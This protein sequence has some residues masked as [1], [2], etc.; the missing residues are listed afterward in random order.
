MTQQ[1]VWSIAD[2][3]P[4]D[5]ARFGGKGAGLARMAAADIPVPPAFVIGT[6][7]FHAYRSTGALSDRIKEQVAAAVRALEQATGRRFGNG[8]GEALPLLVSVRSGAQISMPGMM[9]TVLNLG[10][11][12]VGAERL[13]QDASNPKFA[14]D[15]WLR[16][17]R[18]F[19]DIVLDLDGD[20][21]VDLV[22]FE[23]QAVRDEHS[24]ASWAAL[25]QALLAA[26]ADE[27]VPDVQADPRWQLERAI[28][29]VFESWDNR[30]ARAYRSHQ[31]ID[32][33][34]GTAVTVQAMVFGNLDAQ[35]GSGVAF[36]RNPNDG[37]R[38]LYGEFLQGGQGED[39]VS[40]TVTPMPIAAPGA[41]CKEHRQQL[42]DYGQQ[43]EAM[44]R[45]AVDIEF[46]I[47]GEQ[48]YFLQVRRAKRT[49]RAAA[50]IAADLVDDGIIDSREAL[51]KLSVEQLK[52]LLR[53][54]F[55]EAA[56]AAAPALAEGTPS[57]PG[58]A[59]GV[60]VLDADR[61][62][63]RAAAGERVVLLR[64]NT[65]PQDIRGMLASNAIVTSTGGALS[66]AAVVARALD[67]A[68]VT[69]CE[70]IEIDPDARRFVIGGQTFEEGA[71]L[72]VDGTTG[73]IYS[74]Q[75]PVQE[76]PGADEQIE[77]LLGWADETSAAQYWIADAGL[78][79]TGAL[80][81]GHTV[82]L[83][84]I[85]LTDL[86]TDTGE[87]THFI[88]A[89]NDLSH[90]PDDILAQQRISTL[91]EAA[92]APLLARAKDA[93][94]ALRLP[95]L[96]SSRAQRLIDT[97]AALAPRL[98]LPLGLKSFYQSLLHGVA[99]AQKTAEHSK[100]TVLAPALADVRELKA[101]GEATRQAGLSVAGA[102]LQNPAS[103]F[104]AQ[105]MAETASPL[106]LTIRDVIRNFH[107]YPNALSLGDE[108]FEDYAAEGYLGHNPR[109]SLD[110]VLRSALQGLVSS[111]D[112]TEVVVDCGSGS[113]TALALIGEL[114]TLGLRSFSVPPGDLSAAR[115]SLG[116]LA[117]KRSDADMDEW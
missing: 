72:S 66:H 76:G 27:G 69:G 42:Y 77:R 52:N 92:C 49:A 85:A 60:A 18:M 26:I 99:A 91:A 73:R 78:D 71:Q 83:G 30:R 100:L 57:S 70:A 4:S 34:L 67:V 56:L 58:H 22:K 1:Y 113:G 48:L 23:A 59:W 97:W 64:P 95:N 11:T 87:V 63:E 108:V 75:L 89:I 47:E 32:D 61:A 90:N 25:E 82:G 3:D 81:T 7:G 28:A 103:V 44:Y 40:G 5:T 8:E 65:S 37:A 31:K 39:L 45:D 16:F 79:A 43:L 116:Q 96:G 2:I 107:G 50:V 6:D 54:S 74:G 35:S 24:A 17:W 94:V 12:T 14:L 36:T 19:C 41:M 62:S 46:T 53:P 51:A 13:A 68:C 106:W 111:Q 105:T 10:I 101:F 86:L 20:T 104:A 88:E 38:E 29:A 117:A 84:V 55:E 93:A 112:K 110:P 15:T 114:Y 80:V 115:L 21:V 9:D 33:D 109:T 102:M 98:F